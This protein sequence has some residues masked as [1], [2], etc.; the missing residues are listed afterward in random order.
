MFFFINITWIL[1]QVCNFPKDF[2]LHFKNTKILFL[3]LLIHEFMNL[4]EDIFLILNKKT[5]YFCYH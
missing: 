2:D 4:Y 1:Q 5:I 3:S